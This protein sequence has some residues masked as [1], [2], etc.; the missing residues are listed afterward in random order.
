[1]MNVDEHTNPEMIEG[2]EYAVLCDATIWRHYR[3]ESISNGIAMLVS[4]EG[5][6]TKY[7]HINNATFTDCELDRCAEQEMANFI[8]SI[9]VKYDLSYDDQNKAWELLEEFT[10]EGY[11]KGG[12]E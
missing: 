2:K 10:E 9:L 4:M 1:M 5:G 11:Y 8:H 3:C 7:K 12:E 6:P